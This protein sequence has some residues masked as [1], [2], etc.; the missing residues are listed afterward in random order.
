MKGRLK[1]FIP[2][3]LWSSL[4]SWRMRQF[5]GYAVKSYSQEGED[6]ILRRVFE[7]RND[8]FFVDVGAHHPSRFSNTY[9]FYQLGWS[10]INIDA[11]PGTMLLFRRLRPRDINI[12][13]AIGLPGGDFSFF[14][15]D[16]PALNTFNANTARS[17]GTGPYHQIGEQSLVK[18]PLAAVLA[19]YL[20]AQKLIDFLTVDVEGMDL[21]VLQSSDWQLY[22]PTWILV[23]CMGLGL[24]AALHGDIHSYLD[25]Q[26]YELFAKTVNTLIFTTLANA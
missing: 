9:F 4:H 3:R 5:D 12:E 6:M 10:G 7:G 14:L 22:R 18:R 23:E 19:E 8:G 15:F 24:N 1:Q 16:E 13:A 2:R 26:G 11:T 20:P 17:C 21:E 25:A